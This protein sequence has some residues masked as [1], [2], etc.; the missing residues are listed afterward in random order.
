MVQGGSGHDGT[1]AMIVEG[2]GIGCKTFD[3]LRDAEATG[4]ATECP[5]A[6]LQFRQH[7]SRVALH[8]MSILAGAYRDDGFPER[9]PSGPPAAR[10]GTS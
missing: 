4:W 6:A 7:A 10:E 3:G 9:I 5:L 1:Y 8:P 2:F